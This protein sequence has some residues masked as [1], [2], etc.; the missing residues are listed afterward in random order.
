MSFSCL[1]ELEVFQG[2]NFAF[3]D[4]WISQ[5]GFRVVFEDVINIS[6]FARY[7]E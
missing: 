2:R 1:W 7:E 6:L 4:E 5:N 3:I